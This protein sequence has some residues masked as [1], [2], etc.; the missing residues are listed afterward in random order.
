VAAV[1]PGLS[2]CW[3][4]A[5]S[6]HV[7]VENHTVLHLVCVGVGVGRFLKLDALP[8]LNPCRS[9]PLYIPSPSLVASLLPSNPLASGAKPQAR[10]VARAALLAQHRL[11]RFLQLLVVLVLGSGP[12][13]CS[14]SSLNFW[15]RLK[16]SSTIFSLFCRPN[17]WA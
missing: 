3:P 9:A 12:W 6:L 11:W 1:Q 13:Q 16:V 2:N 8:S 15:L 14:C 4:E 7:R 5:N 17:C 10:A